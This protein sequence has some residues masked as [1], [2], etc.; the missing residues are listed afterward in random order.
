VAF[1]FYGIKMKKITQ[2][3]LRWAA[4]MLATTLQNPIIDK[5][6]IF[7]NKLDGYRALIFNK[8]GQI[9]I[10]SRNKKNLTPH[11]PEILA[12]V[13]K[14]S[15]QDFILDGEIVVLKGNTSCFQS[16]EERLSLGPTSQILKKLPVFFYAF[17]LI[18]LNG[19]YCEALPLIER[20]ALLKASFLLK[21]PLF[22]TP[23]YTYKDRKK[24]FENVAKYGWEGLIAKDSMSSYEHC[25]SRAWIKLRWHL[26][27]EFIIGGFT[28]PKGH[29]TGFGALLIGYYEGK[30]FKFAGKV[31]TGFTQRTLDA[32]HAALSSIKVG[33]SPFDEPIKEHYVTWVKPKLIAEINFA[34]WTR[35]GKL[36]HPSF[37][38]LRI[39]KGVH[40]VVR[41]FNGEKHHGR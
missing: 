38:G 28:A 10:M 24:L 37:E 2:G 17:D 14:I 19:Y 25:R 1:A 32:L 22:H 23:Y 33:H 15:R 36:R 41:E 12:A 20:K 21:K 34:E 7:E 13:K 5:S 6:W 11:F 16:L 27:Q 18:Y 30:T 3:P 29:R 40:K 39:D 26:S 8:N 9:K 4:P 35:D 31:G